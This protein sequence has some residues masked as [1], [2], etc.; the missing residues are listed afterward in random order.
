MSDAARHSRVRSNRSPLL[1]LVAVLCI[2]STQTIAGAMYKWI[3]EKGQVRYS[4]RLP[5]KQ[6]KK[7]HHQLNS[8]GVVVTTTEAARPEEEIAAEAEVRRKQEQEQVEVDRIKAIQDKKDQVLLLTFSSEEELG[9]ARNDRIE[10]LDSVITLINKSISSTRQKLEQLETN[11]ELSFT[12][13]GMEIPGGLAQKIEH[14]TRKIQNRN[15]QLELKLE[16]K[17]KI[18]VQ[19]ELDLARYRQL[20]LGDEEE[21]VTN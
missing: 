14:F 15:A 16:E 7:K 3:D 9:L 12:S 1:I 18:N 19:Y 21:S 5:A 17:N 2:F 20:K 6:V 8:Q 10:V 11:A 13:Q 4:D